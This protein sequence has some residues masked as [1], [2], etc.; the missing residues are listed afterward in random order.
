MSKPVLTE[1][2]RLGVLA[3]VAAW[4]LHP[5]AT[6][7]LYGAGDAL[8]YSNMMADFVT[9]LRQG[10]FPIFAGQTEFAFNGAVYPLR[11]APMYQHLAGALDFLT[12]HQ[13]SFFA[14][15]HLVV[16]VCGISGLF[17][18]YLT[19][20]RISPDRK[21][22]AVGFSILY[23]SCPGLLATI[24]TQDLY[25]TW[26]T[27]PFAPLA[28]YGIMRTYRKDDIKSQFW[29]AVPLAALWWAHAPIALW[30]TFVAAASQLVRLIGVDRGWRPFR[31]AFVG[32]LIFCILAQYPFVSVAEVN[33]QGQKSEVATA[34]S[35]PELISQNISSVFPAIIQPL[36]EHARA[37]GDLQLGYGLWLVLLFVAAAA[38]VKPEKDLIVL[39]VC[40]LGFLMLLL[41]PIRV[42]AFLW[43]KL[44]Q[45]VVRITYYWPMQR[46]YLIL[47]SILAVVGQAAFESLASRRPIVQNFRASI[48][49]LCCAWSLLES[50]QF[51]G[52]AADRTAAA[53]VSEKSQRS[54]NLFLTNDSYGLFRKLPP[55]FS[56]GVVNP[57][58]Q[59]RL[60]SLATGKPLP[61]PMRRVLRS[62]TLTATVDGNPGILNLEPALHLLINHRYALELDFGQSKLD[63]ILQLKGTTMF[64][65]YSLPSSGEP[66]AFGTRPP[67]TKR[68]GLWTTNPDG[69]EIHIRFI[70]ADVREISQY[71]SNF[72]SFKLIE[73]ESSKNPVDVKSLVP[74][75]ARVQSPTAAVLET[76]RMFMPGYKASIDGNATEAG[77]NAYG[78]TTV[79]VPPG[80]HIVVLWFPGPILLRISY[81]TA[82][83]TW[84]AML[85]LTIYV[86][87]R[88]F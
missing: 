64:R 12:G 30:F 37:L 73:V 51:I 22:S 32:V 54:E 27:V 10:I 61:P 74:F 80:E 84:S 6:S 63:G 46:F 23:L 40:A 28:A 17:A 43:S 67:N 45:E 7:R 13:L 14:L 53:D 81:W 31:R 87:I 85:L 29:L 5:F 1:S 25:M 47:A 2:A 26:M 11:V 42:N 77:P 52:A 20:C 4:L 88:T 79:H 19:L 83:A 8:W 58:G 59:G 71:L 18:C 75:E 68:I 86:S 21:W 34:L 66:M 50:R 65:E 60:I 39:L 24:F 70:P 3:T 44:P 55:N 56:N 16:I 35:N 62:G 41:P 36:S 82:I 57:R 78:L 38:F 49:V 69:D 9:Q 76:P 15:Q 48:L 72:G 33:A